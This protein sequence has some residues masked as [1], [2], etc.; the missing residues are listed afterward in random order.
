MVSGR[1]YVWD[2]ISRYLDDSLSSE[3]ENW[4]NATW[5]IP[6]FALLFSVPRGGPDIS[7]RPMMHLP[8]STEPHIL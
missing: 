8:F 2:S 7:S 4:S 3:V 5:T 6:K 1:K